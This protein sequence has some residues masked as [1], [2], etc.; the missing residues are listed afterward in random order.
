[1]LQEL[2]R[3]KFIFVSVTITF[4]NRFLNDNTFQLENKL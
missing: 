1:M 2:F 4:N 3:E